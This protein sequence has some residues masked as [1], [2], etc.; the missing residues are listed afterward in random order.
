[1]TSTV[2]RRALWGAGLSILLSTAGAAAVLLGLPQHFEADAAT[3]TA[4]APPPAVPV[5][6]AK[7]QSRRITTWEDFSGRLEAIER[8]EIRPRVGGAILESHFREGA[9]VKKGD[10]LLTI[11]PEPYAAAVDRA[12][13]QVSA[14]EARVA[15]AKTELDRGR[16]LVTTSA[17]PQSGVDQRLSAF[18]EAQASVRSAKAALR[19][20]EL[21]LQYTEVRAPISGRVGRLEVTAGNLVAAGSASPVLTTLVSV[22]PI[23][24]SFSASEE[25][26]TTALARL[27]ASA[28]GNAIERIPV[29]VG[30]A[31]DEGT[32][33]SGHIQLINNEVDAATGTI[34][35]RAAL[36]NADGRLI[37]GQFVRIRIGEPEPEEK[38]VI[39]D[40]A[41]GSDQDKKFVFV[42]GA[43]NKVEYRQ[44][45]LGP[46]SDGL[47]IVESGLKTGENIVV[48]GLQRVRPGVLVAPQQVEETTASIATK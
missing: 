36:E 20:A 44:V 13:A 46:N 15:L 26:V 39:S 48:N 27:Q 35:V 38:L 24:A 42:V 41:I 10:L 31:A 7:A 33:I 8:V 9:L 14:A 32:P 23:Y 29:Q 3:E 11:D 12:A 16:K 2:T 34:R 47:R 30:T 22:D 45:I 19:T 17:I 37:P 5:S 18:D 6:V 4:V 40:R 25:V 21:D 1:M 28:G 43:D